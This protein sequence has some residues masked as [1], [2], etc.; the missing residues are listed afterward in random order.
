MGL[1][2]VYQPPCCINTFL[3]CHFDGLCEIWFCLLPAWDQRQLK[4]SFVTMATVKLIQGRDGLTHWKGLRIRSVFSLSWGSVTWS[5]VGDIVI[6]PFSHMYISLCTSLDPVDL[7]ESLEDLAF[8]SCPGIRMLV[9]P[10]TCVLLWV[11]KQFCEALIIFNYASFYGFTLWM[12]IV[13][14]CD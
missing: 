6:N 10:S 11:A 12:C 7:L 1:W 14:N 8:S 3:L 5:E 9:D 13:S 4:I 2:L